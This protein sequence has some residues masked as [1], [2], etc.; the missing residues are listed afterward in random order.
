MRAGRFDLKLHLRKFEDSEVKDILRQMF[1]K[2]T[3]EEEM[4]ALKDYTFPDYTY[5]PVDIIYIARVNKT[6]AK[7]IAVLL[8]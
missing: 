2:I 5:A 8:K 1:G 4:N 7:T 3:S 6:L